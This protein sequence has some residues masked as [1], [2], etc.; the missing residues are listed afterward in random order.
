MMDLPWLYIGQAWSSLIDTLITFLL[1]FLLRSWW[2]RL[3]LLLFWLILTMAFAFPM[4]V[5]W[6]IICSSSSRSSCRN[7]L[8]ISWYDLQ[9]MMCVMIISL[10]Q[11]WKI[12]ISVA[13]IIS[14]FDPAKWKLFCRPT[15]IFVCFWHFLSFLQRLAVQIWISSR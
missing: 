15:L 10:Q 1:H 13:L 14:N 11:Q 9:S 3:L 4:L 5:S 2:T 6:L 8:K 12:A 7:D